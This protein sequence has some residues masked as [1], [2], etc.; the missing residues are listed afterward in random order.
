[1]LFN[2]MVDTSASSDHVQQLFLVL[3]QFICVIIM[4]FN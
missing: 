1:M 3:D 2:G 4:L